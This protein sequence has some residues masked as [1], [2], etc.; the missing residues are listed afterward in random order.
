MDME[1]IVRGN[2]SCGSRSEIV[3]HGIYDILLCIVG[4]L[5]LP[6]PSLIGG[7]NRGKG[8]A[9][10]RREIHVSGFDLRSVL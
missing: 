1:L 8:D 7:E 3:L 10:S 6:D 9:V 4:S 5:R 2:D